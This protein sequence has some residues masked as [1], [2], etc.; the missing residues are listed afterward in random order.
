M[1]WLFD[2]FNPKQD[3]F[4]PNL[5]RQAELGVTG[6]EGLVAYMADPTADNAARVNN[7]E[8]DGDEVRRILV[9]ELNRTFVTPIDREDIYSVS[10]ALDDLIDYAHSTIEEI[11]VFNLK[12]NKNLY[13]IASLLLEAS[14]ELHLSLKRLEDHPNVANDHARRAK[15]FEN[16]VEKVYR[17]AVAELFSGTNDPEGIV[18]M[19]RMREVYRHMSNAADRADVAAN[20]ISNI[21]VKM[22]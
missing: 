8:K 1:K 12:P 13:E 3:N 11:E 19:L 2:F 15:R 10:G 17:R 21:V 7:A 5:I 9:D 4:I 22:T 14:R 18:H 6:L 20:V 16:M